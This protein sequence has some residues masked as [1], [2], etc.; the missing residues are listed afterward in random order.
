VTLKVSNADSGGWSSSAFHLSSRASTALVP[1]LLAWNSITSQRASLA[2]LATGR[3]L[4][5]AAAPEPSATS[6]P[7]P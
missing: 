6:T 7:P 1:D 2:F 5:L 3:V 4:P